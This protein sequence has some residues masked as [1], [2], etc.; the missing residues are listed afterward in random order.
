M[1]K[2]YLRR[3]SIMVIGL[4]IYGLGNAFGVLAGPAGTHAW[5]TLNIGVGKVFGVSYGTASFLISLVIIV[6]DLIG[7]GKLGFG[8]ILNI[9]VIS[10]FSDLWISLFRLIPPPE[11]MLIG[12]VYSLVGQGIT[13]FATVLYMSPAL[14][15]GPRDTFMIIIG[16]KFPKLPIG[17]VKFGI[18]LFVLAVGVLLGAP[19]SIGTILAMALQSALF[20]LACR[21]CRFEPRSV[22]HE[23]VIA[24]LKRFR[25]G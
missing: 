22:N 6:V 11:N 23:D 13:A 4:A 25:G 7:R 19:F 9:F 14:G 3:F 10:V 2:E 15:A 21:V 5:G 12:A 20:Q 17:I 1:A 18:E 8:T 24:T 16:K